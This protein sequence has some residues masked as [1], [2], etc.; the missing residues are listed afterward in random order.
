MTAG[1]LAAAWA[2]DVRELS[3]VTTYGGHGVSMGPV[4]WAV[5]LSFQLDGTSYSKSYNDPP[6]QDWDWGR[7]IQG[8]S[9][10]EVGLRQK[11]KQL[12]LA[13]R[14]SSP[15]TEGAS[16]SGLTRGLGLAA[17]SRDVLVGWA[18]VVSQSS[19]LAAQACGRGPGRDLRQ[20]RFLIKDLTAQQRVACL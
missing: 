8:A 9:H 6:G 18:E 2:C 1:H 14:V 15:A 13:F 12:P 19:P 5:S 7:C 16:D 20:W 17:G 10:P 11:G 3:L 4:Y